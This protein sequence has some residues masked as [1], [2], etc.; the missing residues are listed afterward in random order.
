VTL[1]SAGIETVP[2][3]EKHPWLRAGFSTRRGGVSSVYGE[4]ELNLGWTADDDPAAVAENRRRFLASLAP[5]EPFDLVTVRQTHSAT[6]CV[7]EA[8]HGPLATP[9]GKAVLQGDG[10]MTDVPELMLGIQTADCVPVLLADTRTH[11]V[12]AFHAGWRGTVQRIVEQGVAQMMGRYGSRPE[13][14][15][16]AIGPC[17]GACCYAIGGDLSQQFDSQFSYAS[18]LFSKRGE[19]EH[20]NLVEANRRQLLDA[21][22]HFSQIT[23]LNQCT[24]CATTPDGSRKYFSHRAEKG[25]TGRMLSVIG[26]QSVEDRA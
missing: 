26:I 13:D 11:A 23:A 15:I 24:A 18:E 10:L 6:T 20:L 9:E 17:I 14:L 19:Q 5:D 8:D 4:G 25:F 21:G 22:L 16:A 1:P 3:W 2:G 7:L 12:A